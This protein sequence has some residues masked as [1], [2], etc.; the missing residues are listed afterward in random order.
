MERTVSIRVDEALYR[1][2]ALE[3]A[4]SGQ[5]IQEIVRDALE[6]YLNVLEEERER[7]REI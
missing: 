2:L 5:T 7:A 3:K 6:E 4:H 1:R